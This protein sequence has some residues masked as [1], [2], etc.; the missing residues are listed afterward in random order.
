[1]NTRQPM[2]NVPASV[3]AA[4]AAIAMVHVVRMLLPAD[5]DVTLLLTLAFI[6]GRYLASAPALPG[7]EI[8]AVTSFFTYML[9]HGDLTHLVVNGIW[10]LAF[11]SAV[12]RRVGGLRFWG[13][14]IL[15]GLAGAALHL[16][17]HFGELVPMVGASAA[18]SGQMAGALRLMASAGTGTLA[19]GRAASTLPLASVWDTL[20]NP[21]ILLF[22]FIWAALN[23]VFGMGYLEL[24]GGGGGIAWEAHI[25][26]FLC[27]LLSIGLFDARR[28]PHGITRIH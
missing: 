26:G 15:C 13:F 1:M 17:L 5:L 2:F 22:M 18:I 3:L 7:G 24:Q 16:A 9:V 12:A 20:R 4:I 14:S 11:G 23:V 21:Q 10:M 27:G 8:S 19:F 25:G 28:R 6:P